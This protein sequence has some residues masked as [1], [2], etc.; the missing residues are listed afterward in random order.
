MTLHRAETLATFSKLQIQYKSHRIKSAATV[1][2]SSYYCSSS[3]TLYVFSIIQ[4][5]VLKACQL[6][7]TVGFSFNEYH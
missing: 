6:L 2:C 3:C 7:I 1:E 5:D 4:F